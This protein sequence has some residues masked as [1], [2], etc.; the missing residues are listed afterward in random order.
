LHRQTHSIVG[1]PH[2]I[3]SD[4]SRG[5]WKVIE[6]WSAVCYRRWFWYTL[7]R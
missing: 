4:Y 5:E 6:A 3:S 7:S 1:N 2:L